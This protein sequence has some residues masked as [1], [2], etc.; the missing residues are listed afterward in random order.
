[1]RRSMRESMQE[2]ATFLRNNRLAAVGAAVLVVLLVALSAPQWL[3]RYSPVAIDIFHKFAAPDVSHPLGTDAFGRDVFARLLFGARYTLLIGFGVVAVA[4]VAGTIY[5]T[6]SGFFAGLVDQ[7]MMRLVDAMLSFPS[8]VL[9]IAL[10]ATFGPS[11]GNAML[12]VAIVLAPQFARLAR[13]QAMAVAAQP[14]VTAAV[15]IGVPTRRI[16]VQHVFLNGI[17]PLLVQGSLSVGSAILQT[18]SLGFLGLGAQPPLPEWGSDLAA[19][20]A[21]IDDAPWVSL[22]PGVAI[23]LTVLACNLIGDALADWFD[24]R[25]RRER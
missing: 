6:I 5:G 16:L 9:A 7:V 1:M 8:L 13:A 19:N 23:F 20:L 24:P 18:A 10:T 12:S 22:A 4:F 17:G 2:S 21:Y 15:A 11:L 3:S 14:F 25:K